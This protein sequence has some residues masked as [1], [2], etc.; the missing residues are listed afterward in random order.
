MNAILGHVY[1]RQDLC[2]VDRHRVHLSANTEHVVEPQ[3]MALIELVYRGES[4]LGRL[5]TTLAGLMPGRDRRS[6]ASQ[7]AVTLRD[8]R[9]ILELRGPIPVV[10][11]DVIVCNFDACEP[12]IAPKTLVRQLRRKARVLCLGLDDRIGG[13]PRANVSFAV[14]KKAGH[15]NTWFE[16]VQWCRSIV[17]ANDAALLMLCG[18][19]D[20]ILFGDLVDRVRAVVH[21]SQSW[22]P[23]TGAAELLGQGWLPDNVL[24][25]V[26]SLYYALLYNPPEETARIGRAAGSD[27]AILEGFALRKAALVLHGAIDQAAALERLGRDPATTCLGHLLGA[28]RWNPPAKRGAHALVL[29]AGREDGKPLARYLH[30]LESI[31][32]AARRHDR[33]LVASA[34]G[35][36]EVKKI[37]GVGILQ[38]MPPPD[39]S[40]CLAA[41]AFPGLLRDTAPAF[42]VMSR[43]IP[44]VFVPS[45][46][47]HPLQD[48]APAEML[49][50]SSTPESVAG[51]LSRVADQAD[52]LA[53]RLLTCQAELV[54]RFNLVPSVQALVSPRAAAGTE[55]A[56]HD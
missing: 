54:Q 7:L 37:D 43:G 38:G 14:M 17:C 19:T 10:R 6:I 24:G 4:E 16:F 53:A 44:T 50:P 30:L 9:S 45:A 56:E 1:V 5:S 2:Y 40:A 55:A 27:F 18:Q 48:A 39:P 35:W 13:D 33:I 25:A 23:A 26:R 46:N 29:V 15:H 28:P 20:A 8:P 31:P 3:D 34:G 52:G 51:L 42:D 47:P 36:Q 22:P 32:V 49:L 11:P 41:I 12:G 21:V